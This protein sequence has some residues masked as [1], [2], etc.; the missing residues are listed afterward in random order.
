M[1]FLGPHPRLHDR[2]EKRGGTHEWADSSASN[3]AGDSSHWTKVT[4]VISTPT[5]VDSDIHGTWET[6]WT[7]VCLTLSVNVIS[8]CPHQDGRAE[9]GL[10]AGSSSSRGH[11][12]G[13]SHRGAERAQGRVGE[14]RGPVQTVGHLTF[15]VTVTIDYEFDLLPCPLYIHISLTLSS[16]IHFCYVLLPP[17]Q[18]WATK[19]PSTAK[20]RETQRSLQRI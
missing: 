18:G 19:K 4:L 14:Q 12:G 1:F 9:G 16:K 5:A 11:F 3:K 10:Q 7:N 13:D 17:S 20:C 8:N 6:V 15:L 2:G